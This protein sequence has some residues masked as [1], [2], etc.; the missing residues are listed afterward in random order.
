MLGSERHHE[1][2]EVFD[3]SADNDVIL[4]KFRLLECFKDDII[5]ENRLGRDLTHV[6]ELSID[7]VHLNFCLHLVFRHVDVLLNKLH[8]FLM[9]LFRITGLGRIIRLFEDADILRIFFVSSNK[10]AVVGEL[11]V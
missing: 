3:H 7:I 4:G 8:F 6:E 1:V 11:I 5:L 9:Y 10:V 2:A